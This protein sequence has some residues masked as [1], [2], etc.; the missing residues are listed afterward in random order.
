MAEI[1]RES[2]SSAFYIPKDT[3]DAIAISMAFVAKI[4]AVTRAGVF[5]RFRT[6]DEKHD[7][8]DAVFL[9]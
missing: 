8:D 4:E 7:V 9:G 2:G 6:I 1:V 3:F 5:Q